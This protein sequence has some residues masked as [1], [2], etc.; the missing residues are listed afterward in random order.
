MISKKVLDEQIKRLMRLPLAPSADEDVKGLRE[1]FLR[2][3]RA[4]CKSDAH[5]AAVVELLVD[6]KLPDGRGS[7]VSRIPAPADLVE[8]IRSVNAPELM[9][10]PLGCGVCHGSGLKTYVSNGYDTADFCDC[11]LGGWKRESERSRKE[12]AAAR[13]AA[14]G[15]SG[16]LDEGGRVNGE[17]L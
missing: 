3:F 8:A 15:H 11:E 17:R 6:S 5:V 12:D 10:A 1:E 4:G 16:S 9:K 2:I 13:K 7:L 14:K